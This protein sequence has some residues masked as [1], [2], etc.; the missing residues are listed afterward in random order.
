MANEGLTHGAAPSHPPAAR[1]E[2]PISGHAAELKFVLPF[3][4][5]ALIGAVANV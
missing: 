1:V 4:V 5:L 3:G 2:I